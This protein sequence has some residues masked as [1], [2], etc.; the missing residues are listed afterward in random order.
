MSLQRIDDVV[1]SSREENL[2]RE[3]KAISSMGLIVPLQGMLGGRYGLALGCIIPLVS[4]YFIQLRPRRNKLPAQVKPP[5]K[6]EPVDLQ[7]PISDRA[8]AVISVKDSPYGMGLKEMTENG[9]D[10]VVNPTGCIDLGTSENKV[11]PPTRNRFPVFVI[12]SGCFTVWDDV[13]IYLQVLIVS[14]Y[15]CSCLWIS[16]KNGFRSGVTTSWI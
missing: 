8:L 11:R 1:R 7:A 5:P 6:Q 13:Y 16:Y 14:S 15:W 3:V 9:Y 4:F 2:D 12:Y 10:L